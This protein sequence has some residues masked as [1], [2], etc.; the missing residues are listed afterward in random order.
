M[1]G[2]A[3]SAQ[4]P[5][6]AAVAPDDD[7]FSEPDVLAF[8]SS[9]TVSDDL[10]R[11]LLKEIEE[12]DHGIS[13]TKK[14]IASEQSIQQA[15]AK[16][17]HHALKET[18]GL[19]REATL[20]ADQLKI[21]AKILQD[22]EATIDNEISVVLGAFH[23]SNG[24]HQA[25]SSSALAQPHNNKSIAFLRHIKRE[26]EAALQKCI[27]TCRVSLAAM[28]EQLVE[29]KAL[30]EETKATEETVETYALRLTELQQINGQRE[31]VLADETLRLNNL[32]LSLTENK[33]KE[34]DTEGELEGL[35]SCIHTLWRESFEE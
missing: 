33:K 24:E 28:Q 23:E 31:T 19:Q 20:T 2:Y 22:V 3:Q 11:A 34:V 29:M 25:P 35:V 16:D 30:K 32:K 6:N 9:A 21:G 5:T 8:G 27:A 10:R 18:A 17:H 14:S 26:R 7:S 4:Q 15:L 13:K 12:I 1:R